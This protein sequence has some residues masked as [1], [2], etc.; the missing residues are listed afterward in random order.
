MAKSA[1]HSA[2]AGGG[3]SEVDEGG[4][5]PSVSLRCHHLSQNLSEIDIVY[6]IVTAVVAKCKEAENVIG[7]TG[8]CKTVA[9]CA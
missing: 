2:E 9:P 5:C 3:D 6:Y 7:E 4:V 8:H 1:L